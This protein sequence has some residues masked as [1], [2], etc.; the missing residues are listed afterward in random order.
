MLILG[1]VFAETVEVQLPLFGS[2]VTGSG[3]EVGPR[4]VD[5]LWL[6]LCVTALWLVTGSAVVTVVLFTTGVWVGIGVVGGAWVV[7]AITGVCTSV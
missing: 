1:P 7:V 5:T 6:L 4:L 3:E 2:W